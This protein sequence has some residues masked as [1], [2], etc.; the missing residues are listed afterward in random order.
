MDRRTQ[1]A[2]P[3]NWSIRLSRNLH[4]SNDKQIHIYTNIHI[5]ICMPLGVRS[6][7]YVSALLPSPRLSAHSLSRLGRGKCRKSEEGASLTARPL[8]FKSR[9][10]LRSSR[11]K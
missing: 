8:R 1:T 4:I 10:G 5:D 2:L 9:A 11:R 7:R 3:K 6:A